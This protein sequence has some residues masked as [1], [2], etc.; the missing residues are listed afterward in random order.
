MLDDGPRGSKYEIS[1]QTVLRVTECRDDA[2][3]IPDSEPC[4]AST[5]GIDR[6]GSPKPSCAGKAGGGP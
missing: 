2:Y 5:D 3:G 4:Y 1:V 6:T